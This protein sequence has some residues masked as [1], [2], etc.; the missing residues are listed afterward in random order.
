MQ[1]SR[2][3]KEDT[4]SNIEPS[5]W[6][7]ASYLMLVLVL[8]GVIFGYQQVLVAPRLHSYS[9]HNAMSYIANFH[10][11]FEYYAEAVREVHDGERTLSEVNVIG[12]SELYWFLGEIFGLRDGLVL[13]FWVNASS[14]I[15]SA[16]LNYHVCYRL[17]LSVQSYLV[18]F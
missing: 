2:V 9:P 10:D 5:F 14:V 15:A 8:I 3:E 13:S 6:F 1:S 16:L 4:K 12:V 18:F 17:R 7:I 11:H